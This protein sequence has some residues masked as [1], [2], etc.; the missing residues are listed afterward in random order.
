MNLRPRL[1]PAERMT[2]TKMAPF[3]AFL[4]GYPSYW[5][6][7]TRGGGLLPLDGAGGLAGD[8]KGYSIHLGDL[9][10]DPVRDFGN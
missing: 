8:V 6:S 10:G 1:D 9:I 5:E 4:S 2:R 3:G 7:R